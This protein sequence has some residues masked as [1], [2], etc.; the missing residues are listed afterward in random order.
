MSQTATATVVES[1]PGNLQLPEK[2]SP[3]AL[4]ESIMVLQEQ[5]QEREQKIEELERTI[6][7][8][9]PEATTKIAKRDDEITWLRELLAVRHSDLQDIIQALAREDYD[10][11]AVK[12][13]AIRLKA[14][15][16]MEEQERER[17]MNGGSAIYLPNI[18]ATL[19]DA[20]PRVAQAVGPLAAAWGN[21]RKSRE[22]PTIGKLSSVLS[23]PAASTA[24]RNSTPSKSS[25]GG[26]LTP[27]ASGLRSVSATH[28]LAKGQPTAFSSTGRRFTGQD[29]P[30]KPRV[31]PTA[32]RQ[33]EKMHTRPTLP[34]QGL[35]GPITP[36]MMRSSAYDSDA[37]AGDFDDTGFFDD[38]D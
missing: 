29:P 7:K 1:V 6:T 8:L 20:T 24:A 13:A 9:D 30:D 31:S 23:S 36:P 35:S 10:R 34:E 32:L 14:N 12:D 22:P 28:S 3:Q 27:P 21:W 25:P 17:A 16:Q 4:R 33:P 15:L 38:D 37:Q 2:I 26:L 18:A 19:R 5:L 11:D